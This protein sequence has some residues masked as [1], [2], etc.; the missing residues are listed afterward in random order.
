MTEAALTIDG[1]GVSFAG[2][3]AVDTFSMVV[4]QGDVRVLLGANGAGKTT[5]MDL[6]CGKTR[7]SEGKVFLFDQDITNLQ[8]YRIARAGLARKF[9]IPSVFRELTVREN[10]TI[11]CTAMHGVMGNM[12][13]TSTAQE[14]D[15]F[16]QVVET[17]G[18]GASLDRIAGALS[19]GETQWLELG[20]LMGQG[21]RVILLDEPTAGMT[22][23]ET[24]KTAALIRRMQG[25]HTL[26]VVEHDMAF[27]REIATRIT[28]MHLGRFLAEGTVAQIEQNQQ[29]RDAYLGNGGIR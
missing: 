27:V 17:V 11:A 10:L 22:H 25:T 28:V 29:V 5:L 6:I 21:A 12:R 8:E 16:D 3:K 2:F 18:V 4:P 19:H 14:Q 23:A 13:L 7:A 20:L 15:R 1:L 26:L 9:Q 24:M